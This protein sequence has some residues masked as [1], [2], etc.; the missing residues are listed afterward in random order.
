MNDQNVRD[1]GM[2][3]EAEDWVLNVY[4]VAIETLAAWFRE[5][6][7]SPERA[8]HMAGACLARLTNKGI[9]VE[10]LDLDAPDEIW[11]AQR[12]GSYC[13]PATTLG[14]FTTR[15]LAQQCCESRWGKL[16]PM[17]WEDETGDGTFFVGDFAYAVRLVPRVIVRDVTA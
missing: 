2:S 6:G 12:Q 16:Q 7:L 10:R 1:S 14:Y 15:E 5:V 8:E 3:P 9:T 17:D 11:E 4:A 13:D